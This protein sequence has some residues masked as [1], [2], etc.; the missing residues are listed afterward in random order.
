MAEH[1]FTLPEAWVGGFYELALETGERSDERLY[2]ALRAVWA[3]PDLEGC[4]LRRDI[5]PHQ[6]KKVDP[7]IQ[8][9]HSGFHLQGVATLP[10]NYRI[11]CG[12]VPVREDEGVDWLEFYLPMGSLGSAYDLGGYPFGSFSYE[13]GRKPVEDWLS[14]MGQFVY[15]IA[16]FELGLVGFDV[17]GET[18][19]SEINASGI[20]EE[21]IT[22]HLWPEGDNLVYYPTNKW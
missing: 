5:E 13:E 4:Y 14:K 19:S 1:I 20:P 17:S 21:R 11:A 12:T 7:S 2:A 22:G 15:Q 16:K 3:H 6:Q 9:I 10:N 18:Y 8:H